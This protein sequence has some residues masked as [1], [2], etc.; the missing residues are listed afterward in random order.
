MTGPAPATDR[1]AQ[2]R[3]RLRV[4]LIVLAGAVALAALSLWPS[5]E[6]PSETPLRGSTRQ[7]AGR[8]VVDPQSVPTL[9]LAPERGAMEAEV[10]RDVFRFYNSPTPTPTRVPT[11]APTPIL[12]GSPIFVGPLQ[13]TAVP[14]PTP[15]V[16]PPLP[17][18]AIGKFGPRDRPIVTLEEGSR[19]IVAR[20]GDVV[21][22][23]FIVQKINR[24]SVDFAFT[25]LPPS[26]TRRLPIPL[27]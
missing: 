15:I 8:A 24:E 20:E 22:G 18:K 17:F 26:V 5:G 16:P 27:P 7:T 11:P 21:D 19:L 2:S 14:T 23:R 12:P 4:L 1:P 9:A 3:G 13:P 25:G 10:G 6:A